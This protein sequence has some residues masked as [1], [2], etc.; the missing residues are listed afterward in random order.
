[1]L[2][3]YLYCVWYLMF[4]FTLWLNSKL[5]ELIFT[6]IQDYAKYMVDV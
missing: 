5:P 6:P 3:A 1:M 4:L 2:R